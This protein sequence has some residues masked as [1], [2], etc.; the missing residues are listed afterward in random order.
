MMMAEG[1]EVQHA[2]DVTLMGRS[3]KK[4][5]SRF[6]RYVNLP[7][8]ANRSLR[9]EV[10]FPELPSDV[11][12]KTPSWRTG[13][14]SDWMLRLGPTTFKIHKVLTGHGPRASAFL[15][16]AFTT[17]QQLAAASSEDGWSP[18]GPKCETDLT[19][20]LPEQ[21][22]GV[23]GQVLD[24][25]YNE[26]ITLTVENAIPLLHCGDVLQVRSLFLQCVEGINE[27]MSAATAP[28]ILSDC[29]ALLGGDLAEQIQSSAQNMIAEHFCS[30]SVDELQQIPLTQLAQI[31]VRDDLCIVHENEVFDRVLVL[32]EHL[33]QQEENHDA[34]PLLWQTVRLGAL[35]NAYFVRA[36]Q[37]DAIPKAALIRSKVLHRR[38]GNNNHSNGVFTG[39]LGCQDPHD[40]WP[41]GPCRPRRT[42]KDLVCAILYSVDTEA[43]SDPD[44]ERIITAAT[45]VVEEIEYLGGCA[46][47][48]NIFSGTATA[49]GNPDPINLDKV[50]VAFVLAPWTPSDKR[51]A[52]LIN[53]VE[54]GGG[55]VL[56]SFIGGLSKGQ[57]LEQSYEPLLIW[58]VGDET[59]YEDVYLAPV[60]AMNADMTDQDGGTPPRI[61]AGVDSINRRRC[62]TSRLVDGA[63]VLAEWSDGQPLVV[64]HPEKNVFSVSQRVSRIFELDDD[65]GHDDTLQ[66]VLNVMVYAGKEAKRIQGTRNRNFLASGRAE[67]DQEIGAFITN[68]GGVNVS[69]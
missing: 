29:C 14:H 22:W 47:V 9:V 10:N 4:A 50:D 60:G 38:C 17:G 3:E 57:W 67:D 15:C 26:Q 18:G 12:T 40:D 11:D 48:E 43:R 65:L 61:L 31:L 69:L 52:S 46:Q 24:F 58:K 25:I 64:Q 63:K 41:A 33:K 7:P 45:L 59:R 23:F 34:I 49:L 44:V 37:V 8:Q 19:H 16:S 27:L 21:V 5:Y 30:Y 20:I 66:L 68:A 36:A 51:I 53:F 42:F 32:T 1:D 13:L 39:S 62:L 6:H 56:S 54:K 28:R 55:A 2:F 35:S